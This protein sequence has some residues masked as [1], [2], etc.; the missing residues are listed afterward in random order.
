METTTYASRLRYLDADDVDDDVVDF[1]ELDVRG[2]GDEKLG[3]IDGFIVDIPAARV[4][5]AVVDS[6]GWFK[7]RRFL[8]PV[9]HV[10]R[11]DRDA[12]ALR[13]DISREAIR[14]YPS[15]DEDRFREFSDD[16]LRAFESSLSVACCPDER[17]EPGDK[18]PYETRRHYIQ[19]DWWQSSNYS[20]ERLRPVERSGYRPEAPARER[21][22]REHAIA[23]EQSD[24]SPHADG[25]AQPGDVLGIETAGERTYIGDTSEDENKRR[26][27][28]ERVAG[29][30]EEPRGSKR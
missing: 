19:P 16:D 10:T 12:G 1:D 26:R 6:G 2:Y 9:G 4:L 28:A 30:Q 8:L 20:R 27:D 3:A 15:F 5:Y 17:L 23:R 18:W 7:S 29:D 25:R 13:V 24:V 14:Q 22:A 21:L 11:I